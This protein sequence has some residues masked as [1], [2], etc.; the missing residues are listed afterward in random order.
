MEYGSRGLGRFDA[1]AFASAKFT[2]VAKPC[3]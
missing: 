2:H 3:G 1:D